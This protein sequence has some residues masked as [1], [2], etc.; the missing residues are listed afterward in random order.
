MVSTVGGIR[1]TP[2][3]ATEQAPGG[4]LTS[5]QHEAQRMSPAA[6]K[7][8]PM[9]IEVLETDFP[10]AKIFIPEVFRDGRG[11]FKETYSAEKY[12]ALGLDDHFVQDSISVSR[13]NV[14]RGL[15]YDPRMS[16]LVQVLRGK[17]F[18]VI[19]DLRDGSATYLR[20]QS[21][22]LSEDNHRQLYIPAGFGHG[23][24]ALTDNLILSYK[25]GALYDPAAESTIRWDDPAIGIV[26]PL[27]GE[28]ILS[29]KDAAAPT[30][31]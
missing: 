6:A 19:V 15:H 9:P 4:G 8:P 17:L 24:L 13:K 21:F 7:E 18:D 2:S 25:H 3:P 26:W 1:P 23:I 28:P 11:F 22:E 29:A 20:W 30:I 16:K 27:D 5:L 10:E 31:A 14:L 12:R